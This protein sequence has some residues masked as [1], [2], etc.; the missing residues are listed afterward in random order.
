MNLLIC[1]DIISQP[2]TSSNFHLSVS[3]VLQ[4]AWLTKTKVMSGFPPQ[5][6]SLAETLENQLPYQ[7]ERVQNSIKHARFWDMTVDRPDK[8]RYR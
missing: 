2:H 3:G 5:L 1:D 8:G 4:A 7:D 6:V